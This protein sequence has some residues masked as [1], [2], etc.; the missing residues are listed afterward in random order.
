MNVK[1]SIIVPVYNAG[2]YINK[3]IESILNQTLTEFEIILVNDGSTDESGKICD[4]FAE[5]D[6]KIIV[7]HKENEGVSA[8]RNTGINYAV[9]EYI[10]FVDADDWCAETMYDY[11]YKESDCNKADM[12]FCNYYTYK[13]GKAIRNQE[14]EKLTISS[15]I[16]EDLISRILS[17]NSN[18]ISGTCF[19][20]IVK[21]D[22]MKRY[23]IK[24]N[25]RFRIFEDLLFTLQCL[26]NTRNVV[27]AKEYLYY[28]LLH[29]CSTTSNYIDNLYENVLGIQEEIQ[30]L[31]T[32]NSS[33]GKYLQLLEAWLAD[34]IAFI[35]SN[36][37][38]KGTPYRIPERIH[39]LIKIQKDK[40]IA[41][42]I[43]NI[44][45]SKELISTQKHLQIRLM[46][47][48][49]VTILV[50]CHSIKKRTLFR[51]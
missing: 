31:N 12:V 22:F 30:K 1:V 41:E 5:L 49:N 2:R 23:Q 50:L 46:K 19:R 4:D 33:K 32:F 25:D 28:R 37:C 8:A 36:I 18:R 24:F 21:R 14:L 6:S 45:F 17:V 7:I 10:G 47:N 38:R 11:L 20:Y 16:Q 15:N 51:I 3:C 9:G 39:Y 43:R 27:I 13:G 40:R 44:D 34:G 26:D 42:S 48:R 35:A 29:S